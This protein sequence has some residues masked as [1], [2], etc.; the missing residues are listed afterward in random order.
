MFSSIMRSPVVKPQQALN[1]AT[2]SN[3]TTA[4][5][6][7]DQ[8]KGE[9]YGQV[10]KQVGQSDE[11]KS[12][13]LAQL[14][15]AL[16]WF[17]Q[18][19]RGGFN[20]GALDKWINRYPLHADTL[21]ASYELETGNIA[22]MLLDYVRNKPVSDIDE[23]ILSLASCKIEPRSEWQTDELLLMLKNVSKGKQDGE[24]DRETERRANPSVGSSD[25][26]KSTKDENELLID[27]EQR[28]EQQQSVTEK[29]TQANL[30][31]QDLV[32]LQIDAE[33]QQIVSCQQQLQQA[34]Q[35][36]QALEQRWL[37]QASNEQN[38]TQVDNQVLRSRSRPTSEK[39]GED[40]I[41][42]RARD[43]Y[44]ASTEKGVGKMTNVKKR[45]NS[46]VSQ[47]AGQVTSLF[48]QGP[49]P[50]ETKPKVAA[51]INQRPVI[52][53]IMKPDSLFTTQNQVSEGSRKFNEPQQSAEATFQSYRPAQR[54]QF[55]RNDPFEVERV[56]RMVQ[57]YQQMTTT[58][59]PEAS[60][61]L[62]SQTST[63]SKRA[64]NVLSASP[65][66][67]F[68]ASASQAK[69][70]SYENDSDYDSQISRKSLTKSEKLVSSESED[71]NS[72]GAEAELRNGKLSGRRRHDRTSSDDDTLARLTTALQ[73][74][75]GSN[76]ISIDPLRSSEQDIEEWFNT[77]DRLT[78]CNDW[79]DTKKG[80][81]LPSFFREQIV[82]YWEQMPENCQHDYA[83]IKK[84]IIGRT[85]PENAIDKYVRQFYNLTQGNESVE[86]FNSKLVKLAKKAQIKEEQRLVSQFTTGLRLELRKM[87]GPSKFK[88][89]S[90]AARAAK[91]A[92]G[93]EEEEKAESTQFK[94]QINAVQPTKPGG[95]NNSSKDESSAKDIKS[96]RC[97][98]CG[99]IGHIASECELNGSGK[100]EKF[101]KRVGSRAARQRSLKSSAPTTLQNNQFKSTEQDQR[102]L[103]SQV[104]QQHQFSQQP[105]LQPYQQQ[106]QMQQQY[107]QNV[108]GQ[109]SYYETPYDPQQQQQQYEAADGS[110]MNGQCFEC[111]DFSH[112]ARVCPVR[113]QRLSNYQCRNCGNFGHKERHCYA[114]N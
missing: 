91:R 50:P 54:V 76:S 61:R 85:R 65:P 4:S 19:Q 22:N 2:S 18:G 102:S 88:S 9:E 13:A 5:S 15:V 28:Q 77:Y 31:P 94:E 103:H 26:E 104:A 40:E 70:R 39:Q 30:L 7:H 81:R 63:N 55:D 23:R 25:E 95:P 38:Q 12:E 105:Q 93:L 16:N 86:Q 108:Y 82:T 114:G 62:S 90:E 107:K 69:Y 109:Q 89:L 27:L 20:K 67:T 97:Y 8:Y 87:M 58:S 34:Q 49:K 83:L 112:F 106:R 99:E 43:E 57:Q 32:D 113:R 100:F 41:G 44:D 33:W 111:G 42:L 110:K 46:F 92:E 53:S 14:A 48:K 60:A 101:K 98:R 74:I 71:E 64:I 72:Q 47:I 29:T 17:Q 3:N 21:K 59:Q 36:A 75:G 45:A 51:A 24:H 10:N 11:P 79:D 37:D 52:Q 73:S 78:A 1:S 96:I 35:R 6:L 56:K 68:N 84:F 66:S 80:K